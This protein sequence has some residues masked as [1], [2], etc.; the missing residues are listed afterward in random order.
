[1]SE[2]PAVVVVEEK[3]SPELTETPAAKELE[4]A[5]EGAKEP[6]VA[7]EVPKENWAVKKL[8]ERVD[9]LTAEKKQREGELAALR[10][11]KPPD[12]DEVI[13]R[14]IDE[15]AEIKARDLAARMKFNEDTGKVVSVGRTSFPD[16][17]SKVEQ[18]RTAVLDPSDSEG[19]GTRYVQ[20]ISGI[21][22]T[23]DG[24]PAISAKII[25]ALGS[26]PESAEKLVSMSPVR[27]GR[28]LAKMAERD[29]VEEGSKVPKPPSV[30]VGGRSG[31]HTPIDPNDPT[32]AD[33]L[34]MSEWMARRSAHVKAERDRGVR[35]R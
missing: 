24:D 29:P 4:A 22:E 20:L 18:F 3:V 11:A 7:V 17:D 16:F 14:Q 30:V 23:A 10:A 32:R 13:Q 19:S 12:P 27:L 35:I 5:V 6:K 31:A 33:K 1:M 26:D 8:K 34:S 2:E 21:L 15:K 25:H 9:R 28:E